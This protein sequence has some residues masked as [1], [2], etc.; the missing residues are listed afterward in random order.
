MTLMDAY[1]QLY[2]IVASRY[3]CRS[4][5][6]A[7]VSREMVLAILDTARLALSACNRQP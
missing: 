4:Y 5:T 7:P 1:P 6:P 2:D 3:S